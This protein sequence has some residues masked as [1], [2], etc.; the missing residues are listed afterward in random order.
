[1]IQFTQFE[2]GSQITSQIVGAFAKDGL[3][4]VAD[5]D[6]ADG[7]QLLQLVVVDQ[8]QRLDLHP[9]TGQAGIKTEDVIPAPQGVHQRQ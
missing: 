2:P 8:P 7:P 9:Q 6:H 5:D 4:L 3:H 1:M